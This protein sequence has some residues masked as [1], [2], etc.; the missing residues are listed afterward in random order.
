MQNG[1][2]SHRLGARSQ[3]AVETGLAIWSNVRVTAGSVGESAGAQGDEGPGVLAAKAF[4]GHLVA[5]RVAYF[6]P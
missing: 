2:N 4:Q 3:Q 5:P 6:V 1:C